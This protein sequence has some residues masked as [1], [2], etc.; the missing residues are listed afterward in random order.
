MTPQ[1]LAW[2]LTKAT[3]AHD[4]TAWE[5]T[6]IADLV[7]RHAR[8]GDKMTVSERQ[9]DVLERIAERVG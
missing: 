7:K 9:E 5:E 2:V 8:L 4:L 3:A 6:F 1:R